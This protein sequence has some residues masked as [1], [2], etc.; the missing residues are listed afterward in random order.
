MAVIKEMRVRGALVRIHD[1]DYATCSAEEIER[2][3]RERNR[4]A[5]M[6]LDNMAR[7]IAQQ[8]KEA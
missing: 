7:R 4:V 3:R 1:D 6:L 2:R 5:G 8:E